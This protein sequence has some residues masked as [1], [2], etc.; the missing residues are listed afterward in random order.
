MRFLQLLSCLLAGLLPASLGA[1]IQPTNPAG[2]WRC[3]ANSPV[4]SIDLEL[5]INPDQSLYH[6]G[7]IIYAQTSGIYHVSGGGR[8]LL[9]PPDAGSS[10][11]LFH[12][13]MHP[14]AGNHAIFSVYAR[15][16]GDPQ[17]LSNQF[18][19]PQ[20]GAVVDTRCQRL[21]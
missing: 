1:Q 16:T 19:D 12:F 13:Q 2:Y 17:F 3:V 4:Y 7:T 9:S 11:Y 8:W 15:P 10:Q 21:G 20:T 18:Q 14:Q 6:R 5:Q